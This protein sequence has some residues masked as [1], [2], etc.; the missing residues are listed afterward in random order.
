MEGLL[1]PCH[2][3]VSSPL[4]QAIPDEL[5]KQ[6][7]LK[8]GLRPGEVHAPRPLR[9][10]ESGATIGAGSYTSTA[11]GRKLHGQGHGFSF[12]FVINEVETVKK[13]VVPVPEGAQDVTQGLPLVRFVS[14]SVVLIILLP[15]PWSIALLGDFSLVANTFINIDGR[16]SGSAQCSASSPSGHMASL[17][18]Q[19]TDPSYR[20]WDLP[21][22]V[23]M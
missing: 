18:L 11:L 15:P 16:L 2:I 8:R 22:P 19:L 4:P 10:R 1:S 23:I 7:S 20:P 5:A 21:S 14:V 12:F 9:Y 13:D 3:F 17:G 6:P